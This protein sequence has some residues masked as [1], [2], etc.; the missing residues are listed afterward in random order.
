[1][2]VPGLTGPPLNT[3][4]PVDEAGACPLRKHRRCVFIPGKTACHF[5][6]H[7]GRLGVDDLVPVDLGTTKR[8][9]SS[10]Y[11]SAGNS[12]RKPRRKDVAPNGT[13]DRALQADYG[14]GTISRVAS[15]NGQPH[16]VIARRS[17]LCYESRARQ[18]ARMGWRNAGVCEAV[19]QRLR[20]DYGPQYHCVWRLGGAP[21]RQP[22]L[23]IRQ[24]RDD[25]AHSSCGVK[26]AGNASYGWE[27]GFFL[28]E[29]GGPG[30]C[31]PDLTHMGSA[32]LARWNEHRPGYRD[33]VRRAGRVQR[34]SRV[35]AGHPAPK[36]IAA[37]IVG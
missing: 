2:S 34:L 7:E 26:P 1:M 35:P 11:G 22:V 14:Q 32:E 6:W 10:G 25:G 15:R 13:F 16:S 36:A 3:L 23:R 17:C 33:I 30:G 37:F 31:E 20:R 19:W 24:E 27:R 18:S 9:G 29:C 8:R 28:F 12:A 5:P 4:S 21:R